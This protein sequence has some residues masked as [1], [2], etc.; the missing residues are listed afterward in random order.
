M[1]DER[2]MKM[3]HCNRLFLFEGDR[4]SAGEHRPNGWL[5]NAYQFGGIDGVVAVCIELV[6]DPRD[7][8]PKCRGG[9]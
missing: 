4:W 9:R 6:K 7:A 3:T 2:E 8:G 5:E 1:F